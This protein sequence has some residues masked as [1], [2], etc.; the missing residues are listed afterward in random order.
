MHVPDGSHAARRRARA[1]AGAAVLMLVAIGCSSTAASPT[2]PPSSN[3]SVTLQEW[4]VVPDTATVPAGEVT[5]T[6]TNNGPDDEHEMVIIK[7]DLPALGL[8]VGAD[9]KVNEEASGL[10][11]IAEIEEMPVGQSDT[12]TVTLEPGNYL[13]ICNIVDAEGDAHYGK[14]MTTTFVV[15]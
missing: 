2:P 5:F 11:T 6:A 3:V 7:T 10:T 1:G 13:L 4:A 9:G 14:G 15:R 8:P 12:T